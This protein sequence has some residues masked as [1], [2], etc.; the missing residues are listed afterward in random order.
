MSEKYKQYKQRANIEREGD[1]IDKALSLKE[2]KE[3]TKETNI[4]ELEKNYFSDNYDYNR[5]LEEIRFYI[6]QTSAAFL[7][8]GKRLLRIKIHEPHG[9][10]QRALEELN[11]SYRLASYAM[12]AAVKFGNMQNTQSIA[13]LGKT[14][15]IALSVL[16][17]NDI[18]ELNEKEEIFG[19]TLD[20]IENMSVSELKKNLRA[21]KEKQKSDRESLEN[22]IKQK[23]E[24][25]NQL[26]RQIRGLE[27]ISK[28]SIAKNKCEEYTKEF[29]KKIANI[30]M[31]FLS[32]TQ[33]MHQIQSIDGINVKIIEKFQEKFDDSFQ[34]LRQYEDA[35]FYIYDN[36][37]VYSKKERFETGCIDEYTKE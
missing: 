15:L 17:D 7:E 29:I 24:K 3:L 20:E 30:Q 16:D 37:R 4:K 18:Q 9:I 28:E 10:F 31:D 12:S 21:S 13:R 14:K 19:I 1:I 5:T 8:M 36:P 25:N 27:P 2:E 11:I 33:L 34:L 6:E 35:F 26:E 32:L 22:V 23:E